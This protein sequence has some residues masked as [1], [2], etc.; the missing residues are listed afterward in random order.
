MMGDLS[1]FF[2]GMLIGGCLGIMTCAVVT[3]MKDLQD[4]TDGSYKSP[5]ENLRRFVDNTE[6][7]S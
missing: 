5:A 7:E 6:D 3:A 1:S 4:W 2:M